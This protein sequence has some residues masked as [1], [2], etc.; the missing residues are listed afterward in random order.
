LV[1]F[2]CTGILYRGLDEW[3]I[4]NTIKRNELFSL[5]RTTFVYVLSS[6]WWIKLVIWH[7][8]KINNCK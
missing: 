4:Q 7:N 6:D 8:L 5:K 1:T 3:P 2:S